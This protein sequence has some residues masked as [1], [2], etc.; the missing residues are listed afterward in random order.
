MLIVFRSEFLEV[1]GFFFSVLCV[2]G[3]RVFFLYL[4]C[5]YKGF[6]VFSFRDFWLE[7]FLSRVVVGK[8]RVGGE[9]RFFWGLGREDS[10]VGRVV[11]WYLGVLVSSG[12]LDFFL[13]SMF[14]GDSVFVFNLVIKER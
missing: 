13:K 8:V 10:E 7:C 14:T 2:Y 9:D 11:V 5:F 6:V 12:E 1:L 4:Y 3:F